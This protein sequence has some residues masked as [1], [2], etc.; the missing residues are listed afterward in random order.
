MEGIKF[1][2]T[3]HTAAIITSIFVELY[4]KK[5]ALNKIAIFENILGNMYFFFESLSIDLV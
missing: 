2:I 1:E 4:L 3:Y 5:K